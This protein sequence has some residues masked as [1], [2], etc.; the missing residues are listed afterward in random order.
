[1]PSSSAPE[2]LSFNDSIQCL[3]ELRRSIAR[4]DRPWKI[5]KRNDVGDV[6]AIGSLGCAIMMFPAR[7]SAGGSGGLWALWNGY[8]R[9]TATFPSSVGLVW[10]A[11]E[12]MVCLSF[13]FGPAWIH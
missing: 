5:R 7:C 10:S 13:R 9:T 6:F 11:T 1:M 3:S 2:G 4:D 12:G 8:V